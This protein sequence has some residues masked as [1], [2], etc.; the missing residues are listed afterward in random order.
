M[1]NDVVGKDHRREDRVAADETGAKGVGRGGGVGRLH[2]PCHHV[3]IRAD[4]RI[5]ADLRRST[6]ADWTQ[7]RKPTADTAWKHTGGP[8]SNMPADGRPQK[9]GLRNVYIHRNTY[10]QE[11]RNLRPLPF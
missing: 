11:S 8:R 3:M 7:P 4:Y 1:V 2:T 9:D 6:L 10:I 5:A